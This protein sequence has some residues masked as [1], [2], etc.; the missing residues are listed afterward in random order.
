MRFRWLRRKTSLAAAAAV[1]LLA[2]AFAV[3]VTALLYE[4]FAV[5][6]RL[7]AAETPAGTS[8]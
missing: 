5:A 2:S 1:V 3:G 4:R 6:P 8:Q 7:V